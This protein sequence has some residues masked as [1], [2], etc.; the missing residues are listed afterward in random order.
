M[1]PLGHKN[2]I[3]IK[4]NSRAIL[5]LSNDDVSKLLKEPLHFHRM[6]MGFTRPFIYLMR[7]LKY[8]KGT[9]YLVEPY[10][11]YIC[12]IFRTVLTYFN[13]LS[14]RNPVKCH[15]YSITLEGAS[16]NLPSNLPGSY[17]WNSCQTCTV[18]GCYVWG[19]LHFV[20]FIQCPCYRKNTNQCHFVCETSN[21]IMNI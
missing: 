5:R 18:F 12:Y 11:T 14:E 17:C 3:T 4:D 6:I 1:T 2:Q 13:R 8:F 15:Q 9:E 10:G 20:C 21:Y 19:N 16:R 7:L